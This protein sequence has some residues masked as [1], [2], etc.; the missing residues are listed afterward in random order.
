MKYAWLG[1]LVVGGMLSAGALLAGS[2]DSEFNVNNRYTI[3]NVLVNGDGWSADVAADHEKISSPLRKDI[4]AIIG[5][6]LNPATLDDLAGRLQKEFH[7]R[8]VD[9]HI[10]RGKVPDSVEVVFDIQVRSTRFDVA[11]PKFIYQAE[12]GWSGS[13][14]GTAFI[15]HNIF[16][17]GLVSDDDELVERYTGITA[18]YQNTSLGSE[19]VQFGF[20]FGDFHE[21][22]NNNTV[23]ALPADRTLFGSLASPL[24]SDVYR[25]RQFFEPVMTFQLAKPLKL[26]VGAS[27]ES[28]QDQYPDAHMESANAVVASLRFHQRAEDSDTLQDFD[29]GYDTRVASKDLRSDLAYS[30]HHWEFRYTLTR[31][32]EVFIE[33]LTAG[34]IVGQA[35][36]FERFV[37][38]NSTTL[39]G[40]NKFDL[41]PLG[42][43]RMV[44]N[45]VEYRYGA[46]QVFYDSGTIWDSGQGVEVRSSTG[47]GLRQGVFSASIAIP[48]REGRIDP[49]FMLGMNY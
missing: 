1:G 33:D 37:L 17:A 19:K 21:L 9:H 22:W 14:E 2:Q 11:I 29:A 42:G 34:M 39:R 4:L 45:T 20:Q 18:R 49:I 47:V 32:K 12:Q 25:T 41:D 30:R 6:K 3:E 36:L 28:F 40:W 31:G 7:A 38:G 13:V 44:H 16:T 27:F 46:F 5:E 15:K 8:A 35:P 24:T 10:L 26:S 43:N 23:A 48:L